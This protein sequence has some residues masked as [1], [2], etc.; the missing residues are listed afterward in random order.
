MI[1]S[2]MKGNHLYVTFT[3][4]KFKNSR[5]KTKI[6]GLI[7]GWSRQLQELEERKTILS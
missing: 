7:R 5:S 2:N 3:F 4:F 1:K 6:I